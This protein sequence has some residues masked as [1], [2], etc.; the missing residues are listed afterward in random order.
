MK[1]KLLGLFTLIM[2][3][4][5]VYFAPISVYAAEQEIEKAAVTSLGEP[6]W[7][8]KVMQNEPIL[9]IQ[10]NDKSAPTGKLLFVPT[11]KLKLTHPDLLMAYE[12]GKDYIWKPGG[13]NIELTPNS[14]IPFKTTSQMRPGGGGSNTRHFFHDLQAQASYEHADE[15]S[16]QPLARTRSLTRSLS[17]LKDKKPF[18]IVS[19]GDSITQG[20]NASGFNKIW[21]Q[22]YQPCYA[23][24]VANTLQKRFKTTVTLLNLGVAGAQASL[25]FTQIDKIKAEN[26]DL[27]TIAFGMNH[28]EPAPIFQE[29]MNRLIT[30]V[31][32]AVPDADIILVSSM[33][34]APHNGKVADNFFT[35]RDAL[36][37]LE[38]EN[39]AA[40]DVTTPFAE[41]LKSKRFSD[42]SGNN[43]NHPNDFTHRLYAQ[44]I[45]QIYA[46]V[47][48][49]ENEA[50]SIPP[51][52]LNKAD[53]NIELSQR[54]FGAFVYPVTVDGK[55]GW[56]SVEQKAWSGRSYRFICFNIQNPQLKNGNARDVEF[57]LTY[58]DKFNVPLQLRYISNQS[59]KEQEVQTPSI[60]TGDSGE[61]R[62]HRWKLNAPV[63]R[64]SCSGH[65]LRLWVG[66]NVDIVIADFALSAA[67]I[68]STVLLCDLFSDHMV[69]QRDVEIPIWGLGK[70]GDQI[71]V[72]FGSETFK[73]LVK[74]GKW[75]VCLPPRPASKI[76]AT[77]IISASDGFRRKISDIVVGDVWFASGQSNMAM[78]MQY[79]ENSAAALRTAENSLLRLFSVNRSLEYGVPPIG[80][81]WSLSAAES[82]ADFS[83]VAWYFGQEIQKKQNVPIG[84]IDCSYSATV[85][86]TWCSPQV[87][88]GDYPEWQKFESVILKS[89]INVWRN[90]GSVLYNRMVKTVMPYPVKGL[91]WYQGEG[92]NLRAEEQLK[93]FPAMVEDWRRG[94]GNPRLPMFFVQLTRYEDGDRHA[95]RDV[96]RR[97]AMDMPDTYLAVTIDLSREWDPQNQPKGACNHPVHP[98]TKAPIGHRLALA[99]RAKVYGETDLVWSGPMVRDLRVEEDRAI[100][101]FD[102]IGSGLTSLD[103]QPLRG[104]YLSADGTAFS[105]AEARIETHQVVVYASSIPKPVAVRYGAEADMGK[106]N[107]DVNLG[108]CE[109][110]P[111]SPFTIGVK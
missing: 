9:F 13:K 108:N 31:Q 53:M 56:R 65:D 48:S 92:N 74:E 46:T 47:A 61:W 25:G 80:Q 24:L 67:P 94:W 30:A 105:P 63:F 77:L 27:V 20:F 107:L 37:K 79:T 55:A 43:Y 10:E 52:S 51:I 2:R 111:A 39:V 6:F 70:D 8:A 102:Q 49:T 4:G 45:C 86:E 91:L 5:L 72:E 12:D 100:L 3:V 1:H 97:I 84:L 110:L 57:S 81:S 38:K 36:Q 22:P 68:L 44:V 75:R 40:A 95:F 59:G 85:T 103:A 29:T 34:K 62:T 16:W 26:P 89:P 18:K 98:L 17:K 106:E 21:V 19:M 82:A 54:V 109:G 76:A 35:Y 11:G 104:F 42:L 93:L 23:E 15:W 78:P 99:A 58:Q 83:A 50:P 28:S 87:L 90:R 71:M 101:S 69:L 88:K 41:L 14:R 66:G 73:T 64:S 32:V 96:Q 60:M 7:S 33:T